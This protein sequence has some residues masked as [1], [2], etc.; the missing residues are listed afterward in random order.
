VM[1]NTQGTCGRLS[2]CVLPS[3]I[4]KKCM[5]LYQNKGQPFSGLVK[6]A[7][8]VKFGEHGTL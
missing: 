1:I 4:F 8:L 5:L 6:F 7:H 2:L 3:S